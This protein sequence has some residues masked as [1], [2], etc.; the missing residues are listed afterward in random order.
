MARVVQYGL[1]LPDAWR[2]LPPAP[3]EEGWATIAAEQ[4]L[5]GAEP[6]I[7]DAVSLLARQL[8]EVRDSVTAGGTAGM[9]VAVLVSEPA[10]VLVDAMLTLGFEHDVPLETYQARLGV[11][12]DEQD[13]A[14]VMGRQDVEAEVPAGPVRGVHFLIGHLP[15]DPEAAGSLLEE[16]VHLGVFPHGTADLIDAT[17]IAASPGFFD[18]LP[19]TAVGLLEGLQIR[20]EETV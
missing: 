20:T 1:E 7:E 2:A 18:D 14:E 17:V 6:E 15:A 3:G 10:S 5:E 8:V 16:R 12:A 19:T 4:I 11:V 9:R 13:D